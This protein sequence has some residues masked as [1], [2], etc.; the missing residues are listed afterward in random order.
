MLVVGHRIEQ[1]SDAEIDRITA[2]FDRIYSTI[3]DVLA[4]V[5]VQ[6]ETVRKFL[7][8]DAAPSLDS[9]T[10]RLSRVQRTKQSPFSGESLAVDGAL[11]CILAAS[12]INLRFLYRHASAPNKAGEQVRL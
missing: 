1:N 7:K 11:A 9:L 4:Q 6:P 2:E 10:Q 5:D 12:C 3:N 8:G